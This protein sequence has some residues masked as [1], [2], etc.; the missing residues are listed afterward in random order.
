MPSKQDILASALDVLRTG[1]ALTIDAVARAAGLTKPGVVHH[2]S[3]KEG[4]TLA[5]LDHLLDEWEAELTARAAPDADATDRL[6]AYIEFTLLGEVDPADLALLADSRLRDKLSA[7]W[8]ERMNP[9]F[10]DSDEPHV[11]A[12]RLIADGAWIDR[13]LG[14]LPLDDTRRAAV[15]DVAL[16]LLGKDSNS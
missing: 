3:T 16:T 10:G 9:W 15:L 4:L 12:A 11:V 5:V 1:D 6:R 13:C 7:R 8:M 14:M 2:F